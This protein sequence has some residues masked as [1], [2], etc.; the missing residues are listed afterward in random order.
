MTLIL[1]GFALILVGAHLLVWGHRLRKDAERARL[2]AAEAELEQAIRVWRAGA[3]EY[4]RSRLV[5]GPNL[6]PDVL[7]LPVSTDAEAIEWLMKDGQ[8]RRSER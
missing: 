7:S 3:V 8:P 5:N 4:R 6:R 1:A 2:R